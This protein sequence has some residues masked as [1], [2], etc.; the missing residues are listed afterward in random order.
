MQ[1]T[2]VKIR[3]ISGES[4]LRGVASITFDNSFVLNDIR[5]IEGA[6]GIF[7]AMPSRKTTKGTFRDIAHPVNT[8]TRQIIEECIKVKYQD[9]LDNPVEEEH[10]K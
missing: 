3:K 8:E 5:V 2:D 1:V 7:I 9:L 4:R 6:R 10:E